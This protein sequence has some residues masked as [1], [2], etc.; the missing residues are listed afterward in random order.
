MSTQGEAYIAQK[1]SENQ[2]AAARAARVK[3]FIADSDPEIIAD[4]FATIRD[5]VIEQESD[6][7]L[8]LTKHYLSVTTILSEVETGL[9]T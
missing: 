9:C 5:A 7:M 8:A 2:T 3:E 4:L 6:A 1:L